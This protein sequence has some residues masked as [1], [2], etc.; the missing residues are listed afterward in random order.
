MLAACSRP[1]ESKTK[2]NTR[3]HTRARAKSRRTQVTPPNPQQPGD[4]DHLETGDAPKHAPR[5]SP[6]S[7]ASTSI[8]PG[9]CGNRARTALAV[10]EKA[11]ERGQTNSSTSSRRQTNLTLQN[12]GPGPFRRQ[13]SQI[14]SSLSPK[15][16]YSSKWVKQ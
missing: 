16:D 9:L 6:Y 4:R 8:G 10:N 1:C 15:R 14:L 5:V 3:T 2:K 7:P 13:T 12:C 11:K